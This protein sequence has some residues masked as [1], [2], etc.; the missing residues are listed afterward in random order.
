VRTIRVQILKDYF[1]LQVESKC[2][3][4]GLIAMILLVGKT[5]DLGTIG[6]LEVYLLLIFYNFWSMTQPGKKGIEQ[7]LNKNLR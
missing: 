5:R 1:F 6:K 3:P 2:Y 4:H 7:K